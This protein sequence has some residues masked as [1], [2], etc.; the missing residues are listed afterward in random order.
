MTINQEKVRL[1]GKATYGLT[2]V[3]HCSAPEVKKFQEELQAEP[4]RGRTRGTPTWKRKRP[5]MQPGGGDDED[6]GAEEWE[7]R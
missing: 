6:D 7:M 1:R 4:K 2:E 5:E 3:W